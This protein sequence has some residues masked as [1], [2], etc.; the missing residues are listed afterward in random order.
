MQPVA[1]TTATPKGE[2]HGIIRDERGQPLQGAVILASVLGSS[3]MFARSDRD[4]RFAFR[5]L[6]PG[7][8][9]VRAFLNGYVTSRGNVVQV[10]AGARQAWEISLNRAGEGDGEEEAPATAATTR[11]FLA[12]VG[13]T[14]I[15]P[16]TTVP[17][18]PHETTEVEWRLK[19]LKRPVLKDAYTVIERDAHP[20]ESI[21]AARESAS[22]STRLFALF[23]TVNGQ[24]NLLTTSSF[25][26]PQDLFDATAGTPRPVA[27]G[28]VM[29]PLATGDW[30]I[31][32]SMTEGDIASW[33]L[34]GSF[35][36]RRM[37][38]HPSSHIYQVGLSY[39]TQ[40]YQGVNAEAL[41]AMRDGSRN[42]GE[43]SADDSWTL[44]P[45]LVLATGGRYASYDYLADRALLGGRF[46]IAYQVA[47]TDPLRLRL[48][49]SHRELAPGA[50]EFVAPSAGLW[51]PPELT[52]SP[53]SR[54]GALRAEKVD[55]VELSGER[56]V[57]GGVVVAVRA[58]RQQ[59][60]DQL[61][62][63]F[64]SSLRSGPSLGHYRVASAGDFENYGWGFTVARHVAGSVE[65]TLDYTM[66]DTQRRGFSTD[67]RLLRLLAPEVLR[68]DENVHDLTASVNGRLAATATRFVVVYKLNNAYAQGVTRRAEPGARFDV[69]LN[70][71]IPFLDFTGARWEML[72]GVRN[73]FRTDLFEGSVY[74]E[75]LVVRPPK[76]ITGGVTVRF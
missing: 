46:S 32:G 14:S 54:A 21:V 59:V 4:G 72:M 15:V 19:Q 37:P 6:P 10:T 60:D 24:V 67:A 34:A 18:E 48:T 44:H 3:S 65:A 61:V 75:L 64:G 63:L 17:A 8:Y 20:F 74:D 73:L 56:P 31:R 1:A 47:P 12:G 68:R 26:R 35:T 38:S 23:D 51:L 33:I 76:R 13:G 36:R 45:R 25:S 39:A 69:Q 66:T 58:F 7:A 71:E 41:A 52:F 42:V 27:Y 70:Q 11:V 50:E 43:I 55:V 29:V 57:G 22:M 40:R 5:S 28:S 9:L 53:L 16:E 49:A 62:T 2:L 30:A